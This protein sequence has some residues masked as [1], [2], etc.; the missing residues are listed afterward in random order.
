MLLVAPVLV[1]LSQWTRWSGLVLAGMA[2][3][4]VET[5]VR[6]V[7]LVEALPLSGNNVRRSSLML[8]SW[9]SCSDS[10]RVD[11]VVTKA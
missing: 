7:L 10:V 9:C 1:N 11:R 3:G 6:L 5:I 2:D 4:L 8:P